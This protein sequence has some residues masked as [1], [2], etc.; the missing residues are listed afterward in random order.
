MTSHRLENVLSIYKKLYRVSAWMQLHFSKAGQLLLLFIILTAVFGIDTR[1][2]HIYQIFSLSLSILLCCILISYAIPVRLKIRLERQLP[3]YASVEEELSYRIH[4]FND[5]HKT[6]SGLVLYELID[7]RY[8][9]VVE[10]RNANPPGEKRRNWFDRTMGYPK[11]VWLIA[12][13]RGFE[14]REHELPDLQPGKNIL[15]LKF[16]PYKRGSL[17][18]KGVRIGRPDPL[19]IFRRFQFFTCA[20]SLM[21]LP[22]IYKLHQ[23]LLGGPRM[24][25]QGGLALANSVGDSEEFY[26]LRD[27]QYGEPMRHIHWR[28]WAKRGEPVVKKYQDEYFQRHALILDNFT[29]SNASIPFNEGVNVAAS[30]A[31]SF[32]H[33]E[34]LLDLMFVGDQAYCFTAGRGH[35]SVNG[36][37]EVLAGVE[38]KPEGDFA[39]LNNLVLSNVSRLSAILCIFCQWDQQRAD[40]I[41]HLLRLGIKLKVIL[42]TFHKPGVLKNYQYGEHVDWISA[43]HVK[44]SL[45][46]KSTGRS[47]AGD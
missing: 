45:G 30:Y 13:I 14:I 34:A 16:I 37:L 25:Q 29:A 35:S 12:K 28:S 27:Y 32:H 41:E 31:Y 38:A 10:F 23:T 7:H 26:A 19:G 47:N 3:R 42:I 17:H 20:G 2:T 40:L 46:L 21:V 1:Q 24:Y 43:H 15:T 8:P 33:Q 44:Q 22:K 4:V 6:E 18:F 39:H 11:W 36:L 5:G 9:T